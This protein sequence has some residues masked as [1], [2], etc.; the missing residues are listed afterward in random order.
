M[1]R[2]SVAV[3]FGLFVLGPTGVAAAQGIPP[4]ADIQGVYAP[5]GDCT[6]EPRV[7]ISASAI[8][9][10]AGGKT[11]RLAPIDSCRSCVAGDREDVIEVWVSALGRDQMPSEPN[12]R[13]NADEKRGVLVVDK[14]GMQAFAPAVRVVALASPLKRCAKR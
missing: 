3:A 2:T 12:F 1:T 9:I 11:T 7:T 4:T 8:S 10:Q 6:M 5:K 13:I 14:E